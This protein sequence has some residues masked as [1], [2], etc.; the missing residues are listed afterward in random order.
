MLH[1]SVIPWLD[2]QEIIT[3][4]GPWALLVVGLIVFA[5][6]GLLVGFIL[7]GDTLLVIS[8][9]LTH[10]SMVFGVNVWVVGAVISLGAILG[11]EVGYWIGYKSGSRIFERRESGLFSIENVKRTNAF[12]ERF[13]ALAVILARF[14]P[15]V[16]TFTPIAAG[17]GKMH[18]RRYSLYNFIGGVL[19]GMGLVLFGYLIGF[20]P[21]VA[22]FVEKYIDYILLAAVLTAVIPS[23]W[24]YVQS[25]RAAKR[26]AAAG[27]QTLL[28]DAAAE[29]L[30]LPEDVL[31]RLPHT[32]SI[33]V[34]PEK[35][36]DSLD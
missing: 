5:E 23:V 10:T 17:V 9:L 21:P 14:V 20:V 6:T 24:H 35:S 3:A 1:A 30:V 12:F 11:G 16:R 34:T 36:G 26:R 32:G 19:W 15:V 25:A 2:P 27:T 31:E 22:G 29:E 4:A 7:P 8:G 18:R 33:P 28:D 13:G